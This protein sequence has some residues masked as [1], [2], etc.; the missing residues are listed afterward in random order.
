M[1]SW[2]NVCEEVSSLRQGARTVTGDAVRMRTCSWTDRDGR[3][4][5][6]ARL[7]MGKAPRTVQRAGPCRA[8]AAH[9]APAPQAWRGDC[10]RARQRAVLPAVRSAERAGG[11]RGHRDWAP[12][13]SSSHEVESPPA[14]VPPPARSG[15]PLQ[16]RSSSRSGSCVLPQG[17]SERGHLALKEKGKVRRDFEHDTGPGRVLRGQQ[18]A[19]DTVRCIMR[20]GIAA[21]RAAA[22]ACR[23]RC[24]HRVR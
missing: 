8:G 1:T 20:R 6:S 2:N 16:T 10:L 4:R 18:R 14:A 19:T 21:A 17:R 7:G 22:T 9:A 5:E 11:E 3:S 13:S 12:S 23:A 15:D 24:A